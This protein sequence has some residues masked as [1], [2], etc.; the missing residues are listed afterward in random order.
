[1]AVFVVTNSGVRR[2]ALTW[3][4]GKM[5]NAA[6]RIAADGRPERRI[7]LERPV[8]QGGT[9]TLAHSGPRWF[10]AALVH[11]TKR[12]ADRAYKA[13]ARI[14]GLNTIVAQAIRDREVQA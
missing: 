3:P 12:D 7:A 9:T 11:D 6:D 1:M 13:A 2:G 4:K 14:A 10:D 8:T 5:A